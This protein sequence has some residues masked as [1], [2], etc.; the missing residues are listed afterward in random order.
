MRPIFLWRTIPLRDRAQLPKRPGLYAV[1]SMGRIM[2]IG[3]S[4]NLY[5]RW[6]GDNHHRYPQARNLVFPHLAYITMPERKIHAAERKLIDR[7]DTPW[8]DKPVPSGKWVGYLKMF[9]LVAVLPF[10]VDHYWE[11]A[12]DFFGTLLNSLYY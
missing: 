3:R 7:I 1:K 9:L 6:Q 2:Y 4:N 10:L 11:E 5:R 8:N 12:L